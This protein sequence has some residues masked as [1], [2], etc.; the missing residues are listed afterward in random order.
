MHSKTE[1]TYFVTADRKTILR[2]AREIESKF[3][4]RIVSPSQLV[5]ELASANGLEQFAQT[6]G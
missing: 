3:P 4:I 2:Y 5:A 6:I 1:M